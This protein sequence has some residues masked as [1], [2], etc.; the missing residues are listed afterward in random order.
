MNK[1]FTNN[2][3]TLQRITIFNALVGSQAYGTSTPTSDKDYKG[4][5]VQHPNDVLGFNYIEHYQ[6]TKDIAFFEIRRCIELL[7]VANPTLLELLYSPEDCIVSTTPAFDLLR[8]NRHLFLTKKCKETFGGYATTQIKK[9]KG[10]DKM[11]NWE[12]EKIERKVPIDFCYVYENGKTFPVVDW[13]TNQNLKQDYVGLTKLNHFDSAY[14]IYYDLGAHVLIENN[15]KRGIPFGYKGIIGETSNEV[16]LSSI[17]KGEKALGVMYWNKDGYSAHCKLYSRYQTW[18]NERNE[19]R[20]VDIKN[21]DQK[22]DGKNL[23]H[24]QRLLDMAIEIAEEGTINVRRKNAADL[25]KIR[26][27]EVDLQTI[28]DNADT[29]IKMMSEAF[30]KA[31]LP[32]DVDPTFAHNLLIEIRNMTKF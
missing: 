1:T 19:A 28:I 31:S 10:L 24:C 18:L 12:A 7:M 9:A 4:V 21:H 22:I 20:Y 2:E 32:E 8:K 13:L 16:R 26:R 30:D 3:H 27:G 17:P 23:L 5:Y 25:L 11:L 29:K 15:N 6:P 14:A